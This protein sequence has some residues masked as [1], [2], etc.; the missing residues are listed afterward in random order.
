MKAG[1]RPYSEIGRLKME[2][3]WLKKV[4]CEPIMMSQ[5]WIAPEDGVATTYQC[6][7]ALLGLTRR[8]GCPCRLRA[9]V[10]KFRRAANA[11]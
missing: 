6:E 1:Y 3:D 2:L 4:W 5:N 9:H 7:L 11:R 8:R 10:H